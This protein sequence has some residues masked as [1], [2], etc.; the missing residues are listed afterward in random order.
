V[1]DAFDHTSKRRLKCTSWAFRIM[2]SAE[3]SQQLAACHSITVVFS[4]VFASA[5]PVPEAPPPC[6]YDGLPPCCPRCCSCSPLPPS[7]LPSPVVLVIRRLPVVHPLLEDH[8]PLAIRNQQDAGSTGR[9]DLCG[10][11]WVA[12]G[13]PFF[14]FSGGGKGFPREPKVTQSNSDSPGGIEEFSRLRPCPS[15]SLDRLRAWAPSGFIVGT[16]LKKVI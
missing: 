3:K 11:G 5:C 16:V 8:H 15:R 6:G 7:V 1:I 4:S 10:A 14:I 12:V 9:D 13:S 2:E